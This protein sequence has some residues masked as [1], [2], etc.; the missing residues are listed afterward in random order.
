M[1]IQDQFGIIRN[2]QMSPIPQTSFLVRPFL[3]FLT[4]RQDDADKCQ[5]GE[6]MFIFVHFK[7]KLST[8]MNVDRESNK[9]KTVCNKILKLHFLNTVFPRIVSA[10]T[11]LFW[12]LDCGKYSSE[13]TIQGRKVFFYFTFCIQFQFPPLNNGRKYYYKRLKF[14]NGALS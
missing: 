13:E 7:G 8:V 6:I 5:V 4:A 1:L 12:K 2:L 14:L 11:I 9:G 3:L 10:E